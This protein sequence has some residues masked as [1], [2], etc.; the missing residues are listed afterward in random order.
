M[1]EALMS[2]DDAIDE[3]HSLMLPEVPIV[4]PAGALPV[5]RDGTMSGVPAYEAGPPPEP[6]YESNIKLTRKDNILKIAKKK[7]RKR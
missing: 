6:T 2:D 1:R 5:V 4:M 7:G 3:T